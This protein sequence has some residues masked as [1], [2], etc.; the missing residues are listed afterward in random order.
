MTTTILESIK[1]SVEQGH[2]KITEQLINQ[3]LKQHIPALRIVQK[4]VRLQLRCIS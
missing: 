4:T 1:D 3:A 2:Y